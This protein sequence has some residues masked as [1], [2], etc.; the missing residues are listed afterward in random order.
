MTIITIYRDAKPETTFKASDNTHA[1]HAL[2]VWL[3]ENLKPGF[4]VELD[5]GDKQIQQES[6][7]D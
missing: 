1:A 2:F 7:G 4:T 5:T 6:K 3:V